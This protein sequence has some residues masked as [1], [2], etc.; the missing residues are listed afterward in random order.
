VE[1]FAGPNWS[2]RVK[3]VVLNFSAV[4]QG[5]PWRKWP[6]AVDSLVRQMQNAYV[7]MRSKKDE[8]RREF[9]VCFHGA[10]VH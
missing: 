10:L 6:A 8:L 3:G 7:R 1:E 2:S 9:Q 5:E 4:L